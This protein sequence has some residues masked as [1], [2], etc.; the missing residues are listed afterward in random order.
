[1]HYKKAGATF[2]CNVPRQYKDNQLQ[3]LLKSS[4]Y[5]R[6][7]I[8]VAFYESGYNGELADVQAEVVLC[9]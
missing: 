6:R 7:H 9:V 2:L 8:I 1:M 4:H 3:V 5:P